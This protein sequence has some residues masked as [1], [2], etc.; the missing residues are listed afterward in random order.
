MTELK[1]KNSSVVTLLSFILIAIFTSAILSM[2]FSTYRFNDFLV[3]SVG[4]ILFLTQIIIALAKYRKNYKNEDRPVLSPRILRYRT[5]YGKL[6]FILFA[7]TVNTRLIAIVVILMIFYS[8]TFNLS[9]WLFLATLLIL[10]FTKIFIGSIVWERY[11]EFVPNK[12]AP[13]DQN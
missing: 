11:G 13:V 1:R 12:N 2:L 8:Q 9:W 6:R 4:L 10:I 7:D 5:N 3:G